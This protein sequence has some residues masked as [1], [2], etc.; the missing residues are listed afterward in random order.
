MTGGFSSNG[1]SSYRFV[2]GH[3]LALPINAFFFVA[4]VRRPGGGYSVIF[5]LFAPLYWSGTCSRTGMRLRAVRL[6]SDNS[7]LFQITPA[8][9]ATCNPFRP[10]GSTP[11]QLVWGGS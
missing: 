8:A 6:Y 11:A 9:A 7:R 3:M 10:T 4:L 5:C 2:P 1:A